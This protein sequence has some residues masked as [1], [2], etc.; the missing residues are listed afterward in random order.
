[1]TDRPAHFTAVGDAFEP[2]RYAH[3]HW[4]DDHLNGPAVVGLAAKTLETAYGS[5][6]F[7]PARLTVDLFKAARDVP[8]TLTTRLVRDG[9]RV[10]NAE[11]DV[12]QNGAAVAR[13]ILVCYRRSAAPPGEQWL[14]G[15]E[16]RYPGDPL[17]GPDQVAGPYVGSDGPGWTRSIAEHQNADRTRFL[18]RPIDV[19]AGQP[20]S[21]F[22]RA[23][24]IAES[25]SLVTNL[26][27]HGVGYING[28]LTVGLARLP[29][30]GWLGAQ[31]ESHWAGDGIAVGAATLFDSA[32]PFGSG[33]ITAVANPAA[34]I[35]FSTTRFK[36]MRF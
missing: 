27:T 4:G 31:A 1:M 7:L 9:R 23:A 5:D 3:S 8:T 30:D 18:D 15:T 20:N 16:F 14:S 12:I 11:C 29:V 17:P 33:L 19:V 2:T 25:T 36:S 6:E 26:G 24:M 32:G 35:D 10:R 34:Q 13:A 22:V 28:D 21:P